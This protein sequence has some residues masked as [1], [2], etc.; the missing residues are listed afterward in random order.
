[1]T[2][3][4][5][6]DDGDWLLEIKPCGHHNV[7]VTLRHDSFRVAGPLRMSASQSQV[8]AYMGSNIGT[9][10]DCPSAEAGHS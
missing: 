2:Y 8:L 10:I 3:Q 5:R 1:M 7:I 4:F 6:T 9:L